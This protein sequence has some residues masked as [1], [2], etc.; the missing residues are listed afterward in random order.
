MTIFCRIGFIGVRQSAKAMKP[1]A[2]EF[3]AVITEYKVLKED[4]VLL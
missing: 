1:T 4:G 3:D 2:E